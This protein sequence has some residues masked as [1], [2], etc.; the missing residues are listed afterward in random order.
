VKKVNPGDGDYANKPHATAVCKS[1]I[2]MCANS[3]YNFQTLVFG[4]KTM[5]YE[6]LSE[7]NGLIQFSFAFKVAIMNMDKNE[8]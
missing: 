2:F 7:K 6:C 3:S 8:V 5:H 4:S 1:H